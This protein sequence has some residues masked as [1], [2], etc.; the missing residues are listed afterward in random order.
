MPQVQRSA[1]EMILDSTKVASERYG[2]SYEL[3]LKIMSCENKDLD[4]DLQSYVPDPTGPNGMED[5]WGL[6]QIHLPSNKG[7]TKE[8]ATDPEF[9]LNFLAKGLSEGQC[10]KWS[11]CPN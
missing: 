5:S 3:M 9:A 11:C 1:T 6:V 2:V 7:V 10:R 8:Q 4:P